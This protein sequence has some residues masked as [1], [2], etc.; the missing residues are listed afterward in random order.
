MVAVSRLGRR[1]LAYGRSGIDAAPRKVGSALDTSL[2]SPPVLVAESF[3]DTPRYL[4]AGNPAIPLYEAPVRHETHQMI[5]SL[6]SLPTDVCLGNTAALQGQLRRNIQTLDL[7]H[8]ADLRP[9]Q[10]RRGKCDTDAQ[11]ARDKRHRTGSFVPPGGGGPAIGRQRVIGSADCNDRITGC[12]SQSVMV[13]CRRP[14]ATRI[15]GL[16]RRA[17]GQL[18]SGRGS[19]GWGR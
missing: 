19:A 14:V 5:T 6:S 18:N 16:S 12:S 9:G 15:T 2:C 3:A 1:H 7:M 10:R 8:G 17:G 4:R 13:T 11:T